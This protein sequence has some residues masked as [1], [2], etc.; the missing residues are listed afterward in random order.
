MDLASTFSA[1]PEVTPLPDLSNA[2]HWPL[3]PG[4]DF[5]AALSQDRKHVFQCY[6]LKSY[7]E[8]LA[9][10]IL[11]F[12]RER[13]ADLI[14]PPERPLVAVEGFS[15]PGYKFDAMVAISPTI[16]TYHEENPELLRV[17]RAVFPAYRCEFAGDEGEAETRYRY[18]RA[19]GVPA[20]KLK[21]KPHPYV[22]MRERTESGRVISKRGFVQLAT[23]L[24][25]LRTLENRP[26][27][28][29]EFENYRHDVWRVEWDGSWVLT[30]Q[31]TTDRRLGI[32]E[33]LEFVKANLYGPN[34]NVTTSR[35]VRAS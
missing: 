31:S 18:K 19:A 33:L 16:H 3:A 27:R 13:G 30:G 24:H 17:T 22:K 10:A 7:D 9:R 23:L 25:G 15:H 28:F 6:A 14:A 12:A 21:R 32:D 26:D 35:P 1:I 29:V 2:W 11:F 5:A 20:T 4:F 8:G 34:L